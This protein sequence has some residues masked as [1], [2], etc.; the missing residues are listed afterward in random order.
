MIDDF[1]QPAWTEAHEKLA[2]DLG[3]AV[4]R[5]GRWLATAILRRR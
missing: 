1:A 2:A 5:L 3:R 4:V